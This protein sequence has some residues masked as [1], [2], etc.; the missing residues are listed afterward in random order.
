M[1]LFDKD[2]R[3]ALQAREHAQ[4]IAFAPTVFHA[5]RA[6]RDSRILEL[7]ERCGASGMQLPRIAQESGL[8]EYAARVLVEAGLGIG[9]LTLQNEC[10]ALT[11]TGWFVLHDAMTRANM[12]FSNDVTYHGM[13]DLHSALLTG[14]PQGLR[15]LGDWSTVY[16]GLAHL[17]EHVRRSW[18]AFDHYYSD[19]AF[20]AALP[21]VLRHRPRRLMDIGGNTGR[22]ASR[23][24]QSDPRIEITIVDLPGQ[25]DMARSALDAVEGCERVRYHAADMLDPQSA[26]P[27]GHDAIWVSQFL[28]C[29]SE[30][31]V[32]SILKRC[33]SALAPEGR[34]FVLEPLWDRQTSTAAAFCLQQTSLYFTALA[35]GSSRMYTSD[36]LTALV[37]Q[38]GLE[39]TE[40]TDGIGVAHT[41]LVCQPVHRQDESC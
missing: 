25:L 27:E 1:T 8:S 2:S 29:F 26:L 12:D 23:C 33:A 38:A 37:R 32:V 34:I 41:L 5:A 24:L 30:A 4:W 39:V 22:F 10:Y 9:L 16:E 3:S 17:P 14:R 35:N 31:Q 18:L 20:P 28:D 13:A 11:K 36:V 15:R 6:L 19:V 21:L 40:Q 7:V